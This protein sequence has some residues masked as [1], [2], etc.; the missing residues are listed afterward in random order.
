MLTTLTG[1]IKATYQLTPEDRTYLVMPLFHVHGLL[2][3]FLAPLYAGGSVIVPQRF[4]ASD[5]WNDFVTY[6]ANWYSAVPTIHQILLKTPLPNPIPNIRFIRSCSS[7]LS[8]KTFQDLETT[9]NAPVLEA[10]AMTEA[11]H[12]MTSNPL[13]PAKRQS[14]SVGIGMGVD[15]RILDDAGKEVPTGTRAEICV[16]GENVTKGYLNNPSANESSFTKDGFFRTGDQGMKDPDGYVIITGRIKELINKGGEKISPIEVDNTLLSHPKV[17]E[18]VSFAIADEGHYG[19]D[20]GA[21]VVLKNEGGASENDLKSWVADKLAK[22]KIPKQVCIPVTNNLVIS[23][24]DVDADTDC[25]RSG[26][27]HKSPKRLLERSSD[28]RWPRP[29]SRQSRSCKQLDHDHDCTFICPMLMKSKMYIHTYIHTYIHILVF[30]RSMYANQY[31]I[32]L[33]TNPHSRF[34]L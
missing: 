17:A 8:P 3:A 11:A 34:K 25:T 21:A 22:F 12:Q 24:P 31:S 5:F 15:I 1:N 7:P 16:R 14:G 30:N 28:A 4:S 18:A 13:P 26:S 23:H 27:C 29:C 2:A 19:E 20:I 33:Q 32:T 9:F 10:Y 6:K